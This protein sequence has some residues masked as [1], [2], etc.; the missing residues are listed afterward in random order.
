MQEIADKESCFYSSWFLLVFPESESLSERRQA[1]QPLPPRSNMH[2]P[3]WTLEAEFLD[4]LLQRSKVVS[5]CVLRCLFLLRNF[6]FQISGLK[7]ASECGF[8]IFS[9][10]VC[11]F[12]S[13]VYS[14][15]STTSLLPNQPPTTVALFL[16]LSN[17]NHTYSP[18]SP[19]PPLQTQSKLIFTNEL[20]LFKKQSPRD[21]PGVFFINQYF[22]L[23][24]C[25]SNPLFLEHFLEHPFKS[26]FCL[27]VLDV[28]LDRDPDP[29]NRRPS[30]PEAR[31]ERLRL[32]GHQVRTRSAE[33]RPGRAKK[34]LSGGVGKAEGFGGG[35]SW[36]WRKKEKK[37]CSMGYGFVCMFFEGFFLCL[38]F[39]FHGY[40]LGKRGGW[41]GG[42]VSLL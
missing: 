34:A 35:S 30:P 8:Q 26:P 17:L 10:F 5:F 12:H 32:S 13:C 40:F 33:P 24:K 19:D 7:S 18:P 38:L 22:V 4:V 3:I 42:N 29:R 14:L 1:W 21:H 36:E 23:K 2:V 6:G 28:S 39:L 11:F 31:H 16:P 37:G 27:S 15:S 9:G 41:V 25:L 20:F